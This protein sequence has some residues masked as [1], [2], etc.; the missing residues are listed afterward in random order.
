M[1]TA[2]TIAATGVLAAG[3]GGIA[4]DA[5]DLAGRHLPDRPFIVAIA[6]A[7]SATVVLGLRAI[8]LGPSHVGAM[9]LG[10]ALGREKQR[11]DDAHQRSLAGVA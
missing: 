6:V 4:V 10:E 9:R 2:T 1:P 3:W 7:A 8:L 5:F 11:R